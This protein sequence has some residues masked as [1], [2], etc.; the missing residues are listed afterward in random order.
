MD[1]RGNRNRLQ[2]SV[3]YGLTVPAVSVRCRQLGIFKNTGETL[4]RDEVAEFDR[5]DR[6]L[7]HPPKGYSK[8]IN[9]YREWI[10]DCDT[11]AK[12]PL[13]TES[14]ERFR[15]ALQ[16]L[17]Q[18]TIETYL[19][20]LYPFII[21]DF[22]EQAIESNRR[23][24]A[25]RAIGLFNLSPSQLEGDVCDAVSGYRLV[26]TDL[27]WKVESQLYDASK[28]GK[29]L[30]RAYDSK[31]QLG[32]MDWSNVFA[33]VAFLV[34]ANFE[35]S[36]FT[37][38]DLSGSLLVKSVFSRAE[39]SRAI[40]TDCS[41]QSAMFDGA[42]GERVSLERSQIRNSSWRNAK[43]RQS[44]FRWVDAVDSRFIQADLAGSSLTGGN[45]SN[46]N[47]SGANLSGADLTDANF[48][49]SNLSNADLRG[50]AINNLNLTG[51]DIQNVLLD[52][53]IT[54]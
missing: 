44:N 21:E 53:G 19:S 35:G 40:F 9:G 6:F 31:A 22:L 47:F 1:I 26:R 32:E 51:A 42:V 43:L 49:N 54:L 50:A 2:L 12:I 39:L 34:E 5:Y 29:A 15:I 37:G 48:S 33:R 38:S 11:E 3:E 52:P 36:R 23:L 8:N 30:E 17:P 13:T 7:K 4:T 24:T 27:G 45:F 16:A 28:R 41:M 18:P 14:L 10:S 25:E 46:S 20:H